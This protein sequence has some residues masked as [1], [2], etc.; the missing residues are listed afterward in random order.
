MMPGVCIACRLSFQVCKCKPDILGTPQP[1]R[2]TPWHPR[3]IE[4]WM[5]EPM[6]DKPEF[7]VIIGGPKLPEQ[8]AGFVKRTAP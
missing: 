7:D 5:N 8:L 2:S 4:K 1:G 6:P 3:K